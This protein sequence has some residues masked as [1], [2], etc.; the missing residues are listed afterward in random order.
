MRQKSSPKT[1]ERVAN[2]AEALRLRIQGLGYVAI[3]EAMGISLTTAYE[4]VQRELK[5]LREQC[6]ELAEQIRDTELMRLDE[7]QAAHWPKA[8]NAD[9]SST[10]QVLAIMGRRAKLLGID[11]PEKIE[12]AP[13]P[14]TELLIE[15]LAA[16]LA[17]DTPEATSEA[18]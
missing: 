15:K 18:I 12:M 10:N 16:R 1:V 9:P 2:A 14:D 5:R 11:A 3:G 17:N 4:L 13:P 8:V 6:T 7:L